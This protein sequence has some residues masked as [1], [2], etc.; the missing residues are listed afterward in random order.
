M[1]RARRYLILFLLVTFFISLLARLFYLQI[2]GYHRFTNMAAEQ[3]NRVIRIEP[4]RGAIYDR[5]ME[6]LAISLDSPSIYADPHL[7]RDKESVSG[8]LSGVLDVD[9][10]ALLERLNRDKSFAW[11]KRKVG[12]DTAR[13]VQEMGLQGVYFLNES[14]RHYPNDNMATHVIGF[15]GI[16]NTG[17]EGIE[18]QYDEKLKGEPGWKYLIKDAKR[19]TVLYNERDSIPP[20]NGY[21]IILAIDSVVQCIAE[22]ELQRMVSRSNAASATAIVM[23]PFSGEVLA[24]ANYPDYNPNAVSEI[25]HENVKNAAISSVFEPGSVFK[26]VTASAALNEGKFDP[27]DIL[28]CEEGSYNVGGR[29]LHDFHRFGELSFRE[30][31]SKS[32]NIGTVKVA[33]ELG[34]DL[35]YEY[36]RRVGF[37]EKTG[38]DLPGEVRGISRHPGGWS[39]SD[40]TTI[41]IG[42][43]IAVTPMQLTCAISVIANGG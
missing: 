27:G 30:V 5:N 7:I 29:I 33:R 28:Y 14:K 2:A 21:N 20:R 17:L 6:P 3:H 11:V 40:M 23:D 8:V 1:F 38:I 16:D 26:I 25:P 34:D 24:L 39:R 10:E 41:P 22:E 37:G 31:I 13:R 32:S 18:L 19:R 12:E 9:R 36:V 35:L 15:A 43:G 4:R 42:Q